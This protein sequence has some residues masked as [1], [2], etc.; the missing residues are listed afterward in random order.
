MEEGKGMRKIFGILS[1]VSFF[2][3]FGVCGSIETDAIA[4]WPGF[5][6]AMIGMICFGLFA[7]LAGA[8][9]D[10]YA[11][12]EDEEAAAGSSSSNDGKRK[13]QRQY[14]A[15]V[16]KNQQAIRKGARYGESHCSERRTL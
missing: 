3:A 15:P 6:R 14:N 5:L 2:Y 13:A 10:T 1:G 9:D 8:F 16:R 4:L 11:Y 12:D 7:W